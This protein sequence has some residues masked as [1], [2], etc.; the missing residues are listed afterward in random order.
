MSPSPPKADIAQHRLNVRNV[1]KADS[2]TAANLDLFDNLV[3]ELPEM[4]RHV[5]AAVLLN[6]AQQ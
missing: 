2:R 5:E 4:G 1:P 3:S 6:S